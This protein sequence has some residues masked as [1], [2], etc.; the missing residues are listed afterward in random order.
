MI[1]DI[2]AHT[3]LSGIHGTICWH[4]SMHI[5]V[6]LYVKLLVFLPLK[7]VA[8]SLNMCVLT[9][10]LHAYILISAIINIT[11]LVEKIS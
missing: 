1:M 11:W 7:I 8:A 4:T 6:L 9:V 10:A 5:Y 2:F 3:Y